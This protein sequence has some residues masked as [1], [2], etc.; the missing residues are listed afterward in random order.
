LQCAHGQ[1]GVGEASSTF[2]NDDSLEIGFIDQ[3]TDNVFLHEDDMA[4]MFDNLE[5]CFLFKKVLDYDIEECEPKRH[6][7]PEFESEF[8]M[9]EEFTASTQIAEAY[10]ALCLPINQQ[11]TV[12]SDHN[13]GS[14]CIFVVGSQ[15]KL[16]LHDFQDPFGIL[17]QASEKMNVSWF[18]SISL[19]FSC[20]CELPTC[21]SF[22]LL[23]ESER[24]TSVC[25]HLLD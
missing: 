22:Y 10:T 4:I 24:R 16:V 2:E 14:T 5:E 13:E 20:S 1:E 7:M 19:G 25:S 17:L 18:I 3:Q 12:L 21:T 9:V 6:S 11:P 8:L 15:D 23:R